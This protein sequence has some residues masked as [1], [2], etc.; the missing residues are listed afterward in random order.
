MLHRLPGSYTRSR[1]NEYR[2]D[3]LYAHESLYISGKFFSKGGGRRRLVDCL[4]E[5][6]KE[7]DECGAQEELLSVNFMG[8]KEHGGKD[9]C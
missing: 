5:R 3:C 4:K 2:A 8:G 9:S 7:T 1:S 6:W